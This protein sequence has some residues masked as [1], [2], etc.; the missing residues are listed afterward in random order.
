MSEVNYGR[1]ALI[2][3]GE[4]SAGTQ[5]EPGDVV[6]YDGSSYLCHTQPPMGTLPTDTAYWQV[7]ANGYRIDSGGTT[8]DKQT[9][10]IP[11]DGW[12]EAAVGQYS[13]S[14]GVAVDGITAQDIVSGSISI[15]TESIAQACNLANQCQSGDGTITFYAESIPTGAM[16]Y[17]YYVLKSA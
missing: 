6:S 5:Y 3:K 16:T 12:Q 8:I 17:E 14:L 9:L 1:I 11:A 7:S 10:T 13:Y 15:E 2:P 4:Y